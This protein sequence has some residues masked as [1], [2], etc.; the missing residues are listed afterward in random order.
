MPITGCANRLE[1]A[2]E[3]IDFDGT[4]QIGRDDELLRLLRSSRRGPDGAFILSHGGEESLFLHINAECAFLCFFPGGRHPGFVP[5][6]MWRFKRDPVKF[7]QVNSSEAD[8]IE[9][10]SKQ[11]VSVETAYQAA[12]EFLHSRAIP[13]VITWFEL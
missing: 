5:N 12:I 9:V 8:A 3:V 13:A 1:A 4:H 11:L 6:G 10:D 7:L 2:V